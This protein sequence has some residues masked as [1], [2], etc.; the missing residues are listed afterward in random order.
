MLWFLMPL[1]GPYYVAST[2]L[3]AL[4]LPQLTHVC[5]YKHIYTKI[6]VTKK[7]GI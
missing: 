7:E 1:S 5:S 6:Q 4:Q 3:T 2:E